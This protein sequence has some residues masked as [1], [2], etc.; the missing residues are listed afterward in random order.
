[1]NDRSIRQAVQKTQLAGRCLDAASE[2]V[3][4]FARNGGLGGIGTAD[5]LQDRAAGLEQL[6]ER[7]AQL[8]D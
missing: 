7:I 6:A 3:R 1:M 2:D 4:A 8:R 5:V